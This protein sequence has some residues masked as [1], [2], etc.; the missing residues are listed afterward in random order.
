M[1]ELHAIHLSSE[2]DV[3]FYLIERL[4]GSGAVITPLPISFFVQKVA[5]PPSLAWCP[6]GNRYIGSRPYLHSRRDRSSLSFSD[7]ML[8]HPYA[9][10]WLNPEHGQ[11]ASCSAQRSVQPHTP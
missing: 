7:D 1:D 2:R 6:L 9:K 11:S 10:S 3:P 5:A 8:D 4:F